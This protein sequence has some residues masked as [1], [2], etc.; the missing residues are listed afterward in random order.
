M[1]VDRI[2]A[3][4]NE[5]GLVFSLKDY[6]KCESAFLFFQRNVAAALCAAGS[7]T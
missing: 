2:L 4:S 5:F 7:H 3:I 1:Y 6:I